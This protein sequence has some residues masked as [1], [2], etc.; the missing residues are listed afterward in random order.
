M[1]TPWRSIRHPATV[2]AALGTFFWAT[3]ALA[4][5]GAV[6][7]HWYA[8]VVMHGYHLPLGLG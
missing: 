4:A 6:L 7:F 8:T 3:S 2:T 1:K 5:T